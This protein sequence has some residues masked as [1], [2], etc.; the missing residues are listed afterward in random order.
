MT[1]RAGN[2]TRAANVVALTFRQAAYMYWIVKIAA[3]F[4]GPP[5]L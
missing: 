5:L 3:R 2:L 1:G 4:G